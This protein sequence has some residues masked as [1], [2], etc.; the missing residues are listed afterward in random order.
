MVSPEMAANH[1]GFICKGKMAGCRGGGRLL[2]T[3]AAFILHIGRVGGTSGQ[4]D[5]GFVEIGGLLVAV[6]AC[7]ARQGGVGSGQ[8]ERVTCLAA[9]CGG[10]RQSGLRQR[11][12]G[13]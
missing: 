2:V 5:M 4:T 3:T 8:N 13:W 6:M 9:R 1:I 10:K 7:G 12:R 11:G